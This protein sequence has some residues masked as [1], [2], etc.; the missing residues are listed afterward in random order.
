MKIPSCTIGEA[1]NVK[2]LGPKIVHCG[3]PFSQP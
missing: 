3:L 1:L 2:L